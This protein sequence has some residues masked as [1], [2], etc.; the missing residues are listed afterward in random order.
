MQDF[1]VDRKKREEAD[2]SFKIGGEMFVYRAAVAPEA[3]LAWSEAASA[4]DESRSRLQAAQMRLAAAEKAELPPKEVATFEM[5]V[6]D[7]LEANAGAN[8]GEGE[9]IRLLDDTVSAIIEPE[10]EQQW[11]A[12]RSP[13]AVH[14]LNIEDLQSLMEYLVAAVVGRP[15][16]APSD[17]LPLDALKEV[18]ST[19]DSLQPEAVELTASTTEREAEPDV[20]TPVSSAT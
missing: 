8:T 12:V 15:T 17:S 9:F 18:S 7:A 2:R 5:K 4:G 3:I 13:G 20:L 10:Y 16:G 14:P 11:R 19:D 1:D 6:A